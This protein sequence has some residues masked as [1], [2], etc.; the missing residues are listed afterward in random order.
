MAG[1]VGCLNSMAPYGGG[2]REDIPL[3]SSEMPRILRTREENNI[4][5]EK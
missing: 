4:I 1:V 5:K 3:L 2:E